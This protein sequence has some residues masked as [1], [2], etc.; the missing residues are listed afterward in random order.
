MTAVDTNILI[1]VMTRDAEPQATRAFALLRKQERIFIPKTVL[2]EHEWVLRRTYG[3][4]P[5]EIL[6]AYRQ[7]LDTPKIQIEDETAVLQALSF[8][9][10][11]MDFADSLHIA[12]AGPG[13]A[14]ATFDAALQRVAERFDI[15]K[16]V[17][18]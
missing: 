14:F 18:F 1:R 7:L 4:S 13:C 12:S 11:G 5:T 2:L 9:E 15:C 3:Y 10:R 6:A 16:I 17:H 8:Y